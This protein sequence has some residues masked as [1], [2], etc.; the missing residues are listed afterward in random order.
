MGVETA[1][2]ATLFN[3]QDIQFQL[4]ING[5]TPVIESTLR[6]TLDF[7][8]AEEFS[9]FTGSTLGRTV[10]IRLNANDILSIIIVSVT[11]GLIYRLAS[12]TVIKIAE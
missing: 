3:N 10:Q 2:R 4:F 1:L 11:G 6:S 9:V 5:V 7:S 8:A 12:L